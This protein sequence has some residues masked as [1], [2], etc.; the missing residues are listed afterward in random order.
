VVDA[1]TKGWVFSWQKKNFKDKKNPDLWKA[2]LAIYPITKPK[3]IWIKG[4]NEHP[5]NERCDKLA[6]AA[7]LKE[8]LPA[9]EGFE[10]QNDGQS[11][12]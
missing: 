1:I 2:F 11:L 9:D 3:F 5:Q 10:A 6:V 8:N 4:H 12:F 7:A